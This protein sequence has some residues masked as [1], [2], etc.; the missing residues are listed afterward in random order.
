MSAWEDIVY[1]SVF[2]FVDAQI[3]ELCDVLAGPQ[4]L[5]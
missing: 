2:F 5:L 1:M 4:I 3:E